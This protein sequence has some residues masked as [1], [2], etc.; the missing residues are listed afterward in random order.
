MEESRRHV[1]RGVVAGGSAVASAVVILAGVAAYASI[2]TPNGVITGCYQKSS[3]AVRVID[4]AVATCN[5]LSEVTLRWNQTGLQGPAGPQGIQGPQGVPG[6]VGPQGPQGIPGPRGPAG[7]GGALAL[8]VVNGDGTIL[9]CFNGLTGSST[10]PCGFNAGR[11]PNVDSGVYDVNFGF[12]VSS[13]FI[14]ATV[15]SQPNNGVGVSY[16]TDA[17]NPELAVF[18]VFEAE[19]VFPNLTDRPISIV[20]H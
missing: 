17:S 6:P 12:D 4:A 10:V 7:P 15:Q 5:P 19:A 9:R 8:L 1:W 14:S 11:R 18:F 20:V 3:G 13:R 2:P 16:L